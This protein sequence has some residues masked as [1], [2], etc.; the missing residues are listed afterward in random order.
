MGRRWAAAAEEA[1]SRSDRRQTIDDW[2]RPAPRA[3]LREMPSLADALPAHLDARW[4]P[5]AVALHLVSQAVR[6]RG[7]FNILRFSYPQSRPLRARDVMS[8]T[9]AGAG[10]NGLV[11]ARAGDVVKLAFVHRRIE[12]ARYATLIVT[13]LPETA[14]ES[15]LATVLMGWVVSEGLVVAPD[16]GH[17]ARTALLAAALLAVAGTGLWRLARGRATGVLRHVRDGLAVLSSPRCYVAHVASWQ[18]LA[19][20]ARLGSLVAFLAAFGLPATLG[21]ALL[22]MAV[23]GGGRAIPIAP[24]SVGLRIAALSSGLGAISGRPVAPARV[25]AFT[26]GTSATLLAATLAIATVLIVRELGTGSPWRAVRRARV[27]LHAVP[28][29]TDA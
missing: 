13:A 24:L 25:T 16:V 1:R 8:A 10:V 4:L 27:R 5:A 7:W 2:A 29:A 23:Q 21:S 28:V 19:R 22:V 26:L 9:F 12:G 3:S 6:S 11:P 20:V 17:P 15:V 14:F 18:A